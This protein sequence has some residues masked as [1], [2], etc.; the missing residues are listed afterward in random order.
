MSST[1]SDIYHNA[2]TS[3]GGS[4]PDATHMA[5]KVH[6]VIRD[7]PARLRLKYRVHAP[8]KGEG[9]LCPQPI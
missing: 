3:P 1:A 6:G 9:T 7:C 5:S 2:A 4:C 8:E